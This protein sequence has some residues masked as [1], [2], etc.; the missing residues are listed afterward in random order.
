[1]TAESLAAQVQNPVALF[2]SD[3]NGLMV[4]LP[5]VGPDGA[6]TTSGSLIFGIGIRSNNATGDAQIYTLNSLGNFTTVYDGVSYA[7]SY[8]DSG[9]NGIF[10]RTPG[11]TGIPE[12]SDNPSFYC[13]SS[14][15]SLTAENEGANGHTGTVTFDVANG[16][17]LFATSNAAF[18]NLAG[19][20]PGSFDW[21]LPFFFGR[22]VFVAI[23][24]QETPGGPGPYWAY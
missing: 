7:D 18:D 20:H 11:V 8:I 4:S 3:N 5:A 16:D 21:G 14:T 1:V 2:S 9:S 6:A 13:P 17:S 19:T 24:G 23:D 15:L 22:N 10:F 12:C